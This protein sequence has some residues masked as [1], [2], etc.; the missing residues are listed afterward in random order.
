M[1][2]KSRKS[3]FFMAVVFMATALIV[4]GIIVALRYPIGTFSLIDENVSGD[5]SNN[6]IA[7]I[8]VIL[9]LIFLLGYGLKMLSLWIYRGDDS[10]FGSKGAIRWAVTGAVSAILMQPASVLVPRPGSAKSAWLAGLYSVLRLCW[11]FFAFEMSYRLVFKWFPLTRDQ[12]IQQFDQSREGKFTSIQPTVRNSTNI[13]ALL[14]RIHQNP[15]IKLVYQVT[16]WFVIGGSIIV[17][18]I[19]L[20]TLGH[21]NPHLLPLLLTIGFEG[22]TIG[23]EILLFLRQSRIASWF[24]FL[25]G[26]LLVVF[27]YLLVLVFTYSS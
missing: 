21:P 8:I 22:V 27:L 17:L 9:G 4:A 25:S 19:G 6:M 7:L 24:M 14:A 11:G 5:D 13:S 1:L 2:A 15:E 20:T 18:I 12:H 26:V 3:A 10:H 16:S 23:I